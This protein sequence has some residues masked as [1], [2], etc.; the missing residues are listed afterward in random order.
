MRSV[1]HT[2][3]DRIDRQEES[4]TDEHVTDGRSDE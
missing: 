4:V 3:T 2:G 1:S